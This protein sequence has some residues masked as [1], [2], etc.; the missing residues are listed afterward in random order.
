MMLADTIDHVA[1]E[2]CTQNFWKVKEK[3]I[4]GRSKRGSKGPAVWWIRKLLFEGAEFSLWLIPGSCGRK[5]V[6]WL[7]VGF[8]RAAQELTHYAVLR[9][10]QRRCLLRGTLWSYL[11]ISFDLV[12]L[13]LLRTVPRGWRVA[14]LPR[15]L[16]S[17][18]YRHEFIKKMCAVMTA[19]ACSLRTWKGRTSGSE[20]QAGIELTV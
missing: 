12:L 8:S 16:K 1:F 6:Q 4:I 17:C 18:Y 2:G 9:E 13:W 11:W 19:H 7:G 15:T 3:S 10:H 14:R 20:T 5:W